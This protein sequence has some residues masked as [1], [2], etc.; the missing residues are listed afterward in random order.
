MRRIISVL[1]GCVLLGPWSAA[2]TGEEF[3]TLRVAVQ[4][5]DGSPSEGQVLSSRLYGENVRTNS[6]GFV[7]F[8]LPRG[9]QQ[10][11]GEFF[12]ESQALNVGKARISF[13][14]QVDSDQTVTIKLP[15]VIETNLLLTDSSDNPVN[16][17]PLNFEW[18]G[19]RSVY[20]PVTF[21]TFGFT[22]L[23]DFYVEA[24]VYIPSDAAGQRTSSSFYYGIRANHLGLASLATFNP[25]GQHNCAGDE[26]YGWPSL[27]YSASSGTSEIASA[28]LNSG[29]ATLSMP[30]APRFV[31]DGPIQR[32]SKEYNQVRFKVT[33]RVEVE[34]LNY[35]AVHKSVGM[36]GGSSTGGQID[37]EGKF[38]IVFYVNSTQFR[39]GD[40]F[41]LQTESGYQSQLLFP[42]MSTHRAVQKTLSPFESSATG[43]SSAQRAEIKRVV[44]ANPAAE[45]FICT[46]I[47]YYDQPMS[48][49]IKVRKRAKAA[50]EYAKQLNPNLSTWFQ[51]KP[52]QARSY[53]G[54]VLLTVKVPKN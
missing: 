24:P 25:S 2:A 34:N 41:Y 9:E 11:S 37:S 16:Q 30:G 47:R 4:N 32:I 40:D 28:A 18:N 54:K 45:K 48:V 15:D 46:G 19:C 35:L 44:D 17:A 52:T 14:V 8:E 21:G 6:S 27:S 22:A 3:S 31:L 42:P 51:N 33:G 36:V 43:L 38:S 20:L 53:A 29:Q 7:E 49:N 39:P 13:R 1:L 12:P 23:T 10:F 50:C 5:N 26:S